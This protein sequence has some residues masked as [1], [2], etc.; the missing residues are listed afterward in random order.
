MFRW[1]RSRRD[2][3]IARD[4]TLF[5]I[6]DYLSDILVVLNSIEDRQFSIVNAVEADK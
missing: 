3:R 1:L 6:A 5:E 4:A 2:A